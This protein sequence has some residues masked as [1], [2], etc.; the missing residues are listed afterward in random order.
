MSG[1]VV[2]GNKLIFNT[3]LVSFHGKERSRHARMHASVYKGKFEAMV[4]TGLDWVEG[5]ELYFA[6]T[7]H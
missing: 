7:N 6:P 4:D 5:D 1:S 3:G 2:T